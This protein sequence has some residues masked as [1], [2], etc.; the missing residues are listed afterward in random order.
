MQRMLV[1]AALAAGMLA[2]STTCAQSP[3]VTVPAIAGLPEGARA[4]AASIDPEKIRAHVRFLSL[5]LLEGRGP[6]KRGAEI[7]A[8]YIATQFALDGLQPA[9]DNGTYFQQVPLVAVHTVEDKTKFSLVAAGGPPVELAYGTEI[10]SKD[11]TG[12]ETAE[13]DAPIVFVGYGIHAPEYKWDDYA[14]V[15]V[16][17]KV[18]LIIVNEPP[19]EDESFFKGK[20]LTY[21]GRWTYKF[22]MASARGAAACLI[23]HETGPAGYPFGVLVGSNTRENFDLRRADG[24]RAQVAVQAW[25][26]LS[27]AKA[28]FAATGHDFAALK[29]AAAQRDFHPVEL[30]ARANLTVENTVR[31]VAS[32][33]VVARL[34]GSDPALRDETVVYSAHWDHL[35]RDPRLKGDQIYNGAADNASGTAVLL[36]IAQ[37]YAA[38]PADARPKR[39]VLFLSVTAEEKGLLGSRFYAEN[40]LYPLRQTLADINLDIANVVGPS[41]DLEV[42]GYGNTTIDDLAKAILARSGRV[43]TPDSEP[44][45]GHFYRSDHFEFAKVGVPSFYTQPGID[46]I[47]QPAGYGQRKR[48]EYVALYYH[49]VGDEIQPWW[50]F[51]GA[52]EDA[53]FFFDLGREIADGSTWPAWRPGNEFKAKRDAM[54]AAPP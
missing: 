24:N 27:A 9:G 8:E 16:K 50:D 40:P 48:D 1:L 18:A 36:E 7:A 35:G 4:A 30:N 22:D 51:R 3:G 29:A 5:D 15:D 19:S 12:A 52:A 31:A 23:V 45:K 13:I 34:G 42:I 20:A 6:G 41:R 28:L 10:V 11:Q 37:A 47:G 46:I 49:K 26:T 53:R 33:N 14:G 21:Y 38:L 32:R 43:M 39:S 25:L 44:G 54:L 17:G 2:E